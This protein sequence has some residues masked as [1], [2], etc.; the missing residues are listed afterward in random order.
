MCTYCQKKSENLRKDKTEKRLWEFG[1]RLHFNESISSIVF[2]MVLIASGL[3][4]VW[5]QGRF[6][7]NSGGDSRKMFNKKRN[8]VYVFTGFGTSRKLH[9]VVNDLYYLYVRR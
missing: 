2:R 7:E 6:S 4:F 1:K 3:F 9:T 8:I 5:R